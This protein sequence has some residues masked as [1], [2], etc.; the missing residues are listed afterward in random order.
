MEDEKPKKLC[1]HQRQVFI[2]C[3][4]V[5]SMCIQSGRMSFKECLEEHQAENTFPLDC[6]KLFREFQLCRAQLVQSS[7]LSIHH[8]ARLIHELD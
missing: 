5:H 3:M 1:H 2:D 6:E 7:T 8:L 4:Y